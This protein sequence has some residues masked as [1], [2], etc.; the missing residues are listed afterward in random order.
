MTDRSLT[1]SPRIA[2][3][4]SISARSCVIFSSIWPRPRRGQ[5]PQLHV[6]DVVGL[7]LGELEGLGHQGVASCAAILARPDGGDDR[8][9]QIE[10]L[11]QALVDVQ[12]ALGLV[13]Q[14]LRTPGDDLDLVV[15]PRHERV[16]QR[17]RAGYAVVEGDHVDRVAGLHRGGPIQVVED[18]QRRCVAFELE[19]Q[20][21]DTL[22]GL[23]ADGP[24]AVDL[25]AL[26][27]IGGLLLDGLD[28]GLVR[29]LGDDDAGAALGVL[30]D[31]GP[32]PHLDGAASGLVGGDDAA[33]T[34]D[35][36]AGGEVGPLDELH[37]V[38][39]VGVG[40]GE[41]VRGRVGDLAQVV[42]RDVGGHAD[43]D[44]LA[45]VDKQVR[46]PCRQDLG[47]ACGPVEVVLEVDGV[48]VDAG[49]H[50]HRQR[51]QAAL[52][53]AHGRRRVARRSEVPV[54]IDQR[55]TQRE[56]LAQTHERVVDGRV[57]VGVVVA[58][59]LADDLRALHMGPVG[60][61]VGVVHAPQ[62]PAM[63]RL[64]PVAGVGQCSRHDDRHGVVEERLLH[65]GLD[66]DGVDA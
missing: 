49:Q 15:H 42:R 44:A 53:V 19:H 39:V 56:R 6:E 13:Q 60:S 41:Q 16:A 12:L 7:D 50:V 10:C 55:M 4:S 65:L 52:G 45:A 62:D 17:H 8:V 63:H 30:F 54:G 25:A 51:R 34:Q 32:G 40:M 64:E 24:D 11:Q 59:H 35:H 9:D 37:E 14:E 36:P 5:A 20:P 46:E 27:Q 38:V 57:A 48:L 66:L 29:D 43:R 22:G 3:S 33:A 47:L 18:D 31:L 58:H 2:S 28:A 21:G 61:D 26:H 23:V 1:S